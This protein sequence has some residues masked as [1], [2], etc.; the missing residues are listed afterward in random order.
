MK[1][2]ASFIPEVG[3]H[4]YEFVFGPVETYAS[5]DGLW[6]YVTRPFD[7]L[8]HLK[9]LCGTFQGRL[10]RAGRQF[11]GAVI[12]PYGTKPPTWEGKYRT[13]NPL[14]VRLDYGKHTVENPAIFELRPECHLIY[15]ADLEHPETVIIPS[16]EFYPNGLNE[17][18]VV[19]YYNSVKDKII[20]QYT[21]YDLDGLVMVKVDDRVIVRRHA[22][23]EIQ[24]MKI[25]EHAEFDKLNRGRTVEFHF[26]IGDQTRLVWVDLD[27]KEEFPFDEAKTVALDMAK[28][29]Q[30]V[31]GGN[32]EIRFSGKKGFHVVIMRET[33][34]PTQEAHD[35][36]KEIVEK[37]IA[38][39]DSLTSSFTKEK[40]KMRLDFS[41]LH[42]DGGLRVAWSLAY[43]T[44][45]V[46]TP[47]DPN[48]LP[49]FKKGDATMT[50]Q[51][52]ESSIFAAVKSVGELVKVLW[53]WNRDKT[54]P[55]NIEDL[56]DI[57]NIALQI[58]KDRLLVDHLVEYLNPLSDH[59]YGVDELKS[60]LQEVASAAHIKQSQILQEMTKRLTVPAPALPEAQTAMARQGTIMMDASILKAAFAS[61]L[62]TY[63]E[64]RKPGDTPEP[65][66]KE[67]KDADV[68]AIFVVQQH[69]AKKAGRHYDFRL[70]HEGVLKSWA[71][72][73]LTDL[74]QGAKPT[75][76]AIEVEPHPLEYAK[77]E[78]S[79]VIAQAKDSPDTWPCVSIL[80]G[81]VDAGI[82]EAR[83][84][85]PA[86]QYGAGNVMIWDS[87][88][89]VT[90]SHDDN[91][92]KFRLNGSRLN[93]TFALVRTGGNKWLL[94]RSKDA[95]KS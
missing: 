61:L 62:K 38:G 65:F 81:M 39:K 90:L 24:A 76:L 9:A 85:I 25:G 51:T 29:M 41:T 21:D 91:H 3:K 4:E 30:T 59:K 46:C 77:F 7:S 34:M 94:R 36:V 28:E 18:Q 10:E 58:E 69:D 5:S 23:L 60:A 40:N 17:Q 1:F 52:I 45:L 6:V 89:Y 42:K 33:F 93:G 75:V 19:G 80:S 2:Q 92:W 14:K 73:K 79:A 55:N 16:N 32:P 8:E 57:E 56:K 63:E 11:M 84:S 86:G 37:Y 74:V 78:G 72:P 53:Q 43:P 95:S 35:K 83:A 12:Q 27:P 67:V 87:G 70:A 88:S 15:A 48:M 68:E 64:K 82:L 47:I 54:L 66:G 49:S 22:S 31:F 13:I 50:E 71:V 44:G 20:K 26:A